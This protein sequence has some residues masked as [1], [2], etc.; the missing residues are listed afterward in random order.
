MSSKSVISKIFGTAL[1]TA[2]PLASVSA[3]DSGRGIKDLC[4]RSAFCTYIAIDDNVFR[5]EGNNEDLFGGDPS[6][7]QYLIESQARRDG[8]LTE[9]VVKREP[10]ETANDSFG[11]ADLKPNFL[12]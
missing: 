9:S 5:V 7:Q 11:L 6:V 2:L 1:L 3:G 12:D 10:G 8:K 4:Y